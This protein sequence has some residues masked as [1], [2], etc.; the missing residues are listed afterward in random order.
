MNDVCEIYTQ[1]PD[2]SEHA[3]YYL[4]YL[5]LVTEE[6]IIEALEEQLVELRSLFDSVSNEDVSKLHAPYTWTI[7][8]AFGHCIDNERVFGYRACRFAAGDTT[9]LPGY[10]QDAYVAN[11]DY[12][13]CTLDDLIN[14]FENLRRGNLAMY[15]RMNAEAWAKQGSGDGKPISVRTI[16]WLLVG[17]L[18]HHTNIFQQRLGQ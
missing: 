12:S 11:T 13:S 18:R 5:E 7:K 2:P 6:N 17:H 8:S 4:P 14:E 15:K 9:D 1:R 10:D 3:A 16:A